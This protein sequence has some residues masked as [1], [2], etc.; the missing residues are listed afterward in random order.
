MK[1]RKIK[2]IIAI[3]G[4]IGG[5]LALNSVKAHAVE[6]TDDLSNDGHEQNINSRSSNKGQVVNVDSTYL[7][8]RAAAS[9]SSEVLGTMIEGT[10]FNIISKS[11]QWYQIQYNDIVGYVFEDYVDE[12][13]AGS[14]STTYDVI[15][16]G[17]VYDA[18]PNLRVRSGASLDSTIIGYVLD[19][20]TVSIVAVEG[21]W[22][23]IQYNG[24]YGYVSADYVSIG[25]TSNGGNS[26][27]DSGS[28]SITAVG[29]AYD[30]GNIA[31]RIR[32]G[33]STSSA[34]LGNIYEG[35]SVNIIGEEGNWYK[36][37]YNNSTAYVSKD[38]ITLNEF[39]AGAGSDNNASVRSGYVINVEGSNLRVRQSASSSAMVLGYLVN[40]EAV[41][42]VGEE[43]SWY[44]INYKNS[45]GYVHSDYIQVGTG[46]V[47]NGNLSGGST[48]VSGAIS[49]SEAYN[50]V[51]NAMKEQVG[52]P[53][54]WGGSGE[55]L[56]TNSLN[57]LKLRFPE[58]AAYGEYIHA[59]NYV[60]QGYRAFDCSGLMQW[61][62]AQAGI[63]IGR[64]TYSQI[65]AGVEVQLS[66]VQPGDLLFSADLAHVGMYIGDNQWIESSYTGDY[67]RISNVPWSYVSRA[68]RVLN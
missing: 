30:L 62:F 34:I 19:N 23:K 35:D 20:S 52:A 48:S 39:S 42:I 14:S 57:E 56:T 16:T 31:L 12:I 67:V 60:N 32:E 37:L 25:S 18:A 44:K 21:S 51:F 10:R 49:N 9:T 59:E 1:K 40:N 13:S 53:Y 47:S 41:E 46:G 50:I 54:V 38:Y 58:D 4:V 3:S 45:T 29:Y 55:Y 43:G 28:S 63:S 36:I 15:Y 33:A 7:R 17:T 65:N 6:L 11:D 26:K 2:K 24:G 61:G 22:Y 27:N 68:R 5:I 8:I 66:S 64:T